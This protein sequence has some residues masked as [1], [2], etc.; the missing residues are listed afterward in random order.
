MSDESI[1]IQTPGGFAPVIAIGQDDG[2]GNLALV[3]STAPLPT[4]TVA[5]VAPAPLEG[6][7]AASLV[8]GPYVPAALTPIYVTLSGEWQGRVTLAR[9][10]DGGATLH[11]LTVGGASWGRF[12]G[13]ACEA[14]WVETDRA[15]SLYLQIEPTEGSVTYRVSQ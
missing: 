5:P 8:A 9:S 4:V 12:T 13:N 3:S 11:P 1:P 7:S 2:A 14:S 6:T 10:T 15:A